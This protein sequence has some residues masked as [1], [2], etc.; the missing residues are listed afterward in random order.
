M[1]EANIK[2]FNYMAEHAGAAYC[3]TSPDNLNKDITCS[4]RG[5]VVCSI[6]NTHNTSV[7]G[8]FDPDFQG[9][10]AY[11]AVDH[12]SKQIILSVR[13]ANEPEMWA[14]ASNF[15]LVDWPLVPNAQAHEQFITTWDA[16]DPAK[17]ASTMSKAKKTHPDYT[18]RAVG[19]SLGGAIAMLAAA[20]LRLEHDFQIDL[21]SFG[22][23]R[24]GNDHLSRFINEQDEG[25][26]YRITHQNDG[27]SN[28]PAGYIGYTH[29]GTEYWLMGRNATQDTYPIEDVQVCKGL[30]NL[31]CNGGTTGWD[32]NTHYMYF[33]NIGGCMPP[34][35]RPIFP[36]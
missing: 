12:T 34:E 15:T 36:V 8:V 17:V 24:L 30:R 32:L 14:K 2:T 31:E 19:H 7:I 5:N 35:Y 1:T 23:P 3:N 18:M 10:A 25:G 22:A 27:I 29:A 4:D 6:L 20:Q 9:I 13:G 21:Y 16:M 33:G 11:T 26:N 28:R